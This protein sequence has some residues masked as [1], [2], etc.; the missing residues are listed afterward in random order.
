M[1]LT[2]SLAKELGPLGVR[3]NLIAPGFITTDMTEG[4]NE[5]AFTSTLSSHQTG[6]PTETKDKLKSQIPAR[7]FGSPEVTSRCAMPGY[8]CASQEVAALACFLASPM[9]SYI[10]GQV[11]LALREPALLSVRSR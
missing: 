11:V 5:L 3:T 9:A 6:L 2:C 4:E 8:L 1:G 7:R 10:N